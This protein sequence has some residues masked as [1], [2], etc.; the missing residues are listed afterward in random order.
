M[1]PSQLSTLALRRQPSQ[2][3]CPARYFLGYAQGKPVAASEC[4]LYAGVAGVYNVVTLTT[5]RRRGFGRALILAALQ[6]A[7]E[8]GYSTTVL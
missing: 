2:S 8:A 3:D 6:E 1:R 5:A 4:F 7:R